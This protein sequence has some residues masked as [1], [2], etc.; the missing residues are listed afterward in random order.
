MPRKVDARL[1]YRLRPGCGWLVLLR[2]STGGAPVAPDV[3]PG[4]HWRAASGNRAKACHCSSGRKR[5]VNLT[6]SRDGRL[7][8][9]EKMPRKVDARFAYCLRPGCGWLVLLPG[10]T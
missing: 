10:S 1:A 9:F 2:R 4:C 8:S 6:T 5:V 3:T 7:V